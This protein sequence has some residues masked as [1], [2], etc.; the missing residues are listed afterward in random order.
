M[1][2]VA[3][4]NVFHKG[5]I[6]LQWNHACFGVRGVSKLTGSNPV[7][8]PSIGWV[9]SLGATN[10]KTKD[11]PVDMEEIAQANQQRM[12]IDHNEVIFMQC[13]VL[14]MFVDDVVHCPLLSATRTPP[15]LP[16]DSTVGY[17]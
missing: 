2:T 17:Q 12:C 4:Q 1:V 14:T 6:V 15:S 3:N 5:A 11:A 13:T 7:H 16:L 10:D 8:G 9:S